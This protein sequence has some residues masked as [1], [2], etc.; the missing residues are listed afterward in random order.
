MLLL[1]ANVVLA[2]HRADHPHHTV[3]AAELRTVVDERTQFTVPLGVWLAVLRLATN[4]RV[5]P[6]ASTTDEVFE[7]ADAVVAQPNHVLSAAGPRHLDTLRRVCS[8]SGATGLLV[9]DAS[10]AAQAV[11]L[12]AEVVTFDRDFLRFDMVRSRILR[13]AA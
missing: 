12:G 4:R 6:E 11:E 13:P 2:V 9:P 5:F 1:D 10:L 7:F 8:D 3:A